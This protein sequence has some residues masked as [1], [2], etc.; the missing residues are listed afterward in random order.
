MATPVTISN[1]LTVPEHHQLS[2]LSNKNSLVLLALG[3]GRYFH[4]HLHPMEARPA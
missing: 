3:N 1:Q 2:D 4:P